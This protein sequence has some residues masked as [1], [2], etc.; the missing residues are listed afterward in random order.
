MSP[1]VLTIIH[2]SL[3]G[4]A[5]AGLILLARYSQKKFKKQQS[6]NDANKMGTTALL[7]NSLIRNYRQFAKREKVPI[8]ERDN[9]ES[10]YKAYHK[11][12][13]NGVID[14]MYNKF[15]ELPIEIL[16]ER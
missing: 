5:T 11:L 1:A 7:R 14:D 6:E 8:Y 15:M 13:G 10:M 16:D 4:V 3:S 9:F 2:N 12:G